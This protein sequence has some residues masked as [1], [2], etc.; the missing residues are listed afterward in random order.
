VKQV[1]AGKA[2]ASG[3]DSCVVAQLRYS[4]IVVKQFRALRGN[5]TNRRRPPALG[6]VNASTVIRGDNPSPSH[7]RRR[8]NAGTDGY[9]EDRRTG[10]EDRENFFFRPTLCI[11]VLSDRIQ[12]P[13]LFLF[14]DARNTFK[15]FLWSRR[16][17]PGTS[18]TENSRV[19]DRSPR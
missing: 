18:G 6:K 17:P 9:G 11:F 10:D 3:E 2:P 5:R 14:P 4:P 7:R 19:L 8:R 12:L 13:H 16:K 1:R 15:K